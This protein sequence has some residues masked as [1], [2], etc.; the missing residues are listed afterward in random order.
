MAENGLKQ[1]FDNT[2]VHNL[3]FYTYVCS[4]GQQVVFNYPML[5][6]KVPTSLITRSSYPMGHHNHSYVSKI[7]Q[8]QLKT[9]FWWYLPV[10]LYTSMFYGLTS[11]VQLFYGITQGAYYTHDP[12]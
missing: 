3:L 10:I 2:Y 9:G 6:P 8:K 11:G 7:G 12:I 4:M 1:V 5:S